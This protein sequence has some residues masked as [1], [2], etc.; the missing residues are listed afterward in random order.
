MDIGFGLPNSVRNA[1][2]RKLVEFAR[3]AED[4]GF[5]ALATID[6]IAFPSYESLVTLAAAAGATERIGLFTNVLLAPTRNPVLLAKEAASV[7]RLSAGRFR[8]GLGVGGRPDDFGAVGLG[9][10]DR[11]ERFDQNLEVIHR[12]W[13]GELIEGIQNP[14]GPTPSN[15]ERVPIVVGGTTDATIR[16]AV[17][18][19]I[20]WTAG[21]APPEA[22]GPFAERVRTAWKDSGRPGDPRI[23]ALTYFSVGEEE[24]SMGAILDYYAFLGDMAKD[25]AQ[26]VPRTAEQIRDRVKAFE[27]IGVDEL[28]LDA[29]VDDPEQV[30]RLAEIVF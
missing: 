26:W 30:D 23:V 18:Y 20:G 25:F 28:F 14:V 1:D 13:A 6:R 2:G 29:T 12:V 24:A 5:S 17:S 21:G 22:V 11:G 16:R 10:H 27:D 7:D 3:R 8:L 9:F 19:G 15:G 4:A